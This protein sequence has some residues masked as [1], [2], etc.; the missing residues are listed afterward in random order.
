MINLK[1]TYKFYISKRYKITFA[2]TDSTNTINT[3]YLAVV[4]HDGYCS[5]PGEITFTYYM[6]STLMNQNNKLLS[7][8]GVVPGSTYFKFHGCE[9]LQCGSGSGYCGTFDILHQET[10]VPIITDPTT[11]KPSCVKISLDDFKIGT[12]SCLNCLNKLENMTSRYQ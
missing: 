3:N 2:M 5:D 8:S 4:N 7:I 6:F 1:L 10:T 12:N 11:F 9:Q